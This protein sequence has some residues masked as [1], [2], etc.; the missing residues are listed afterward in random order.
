M[1]LAV[2]AR[3]VEI[4]GNEA[5]VQVGEIRRR[6]RLELIAERVRVGDYL[7]VHSG[8]AIHKLDE[9]QARLSLQEWERLLHER[10]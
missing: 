6:V 4:E 2:P 1:C 9:D 10:N 5:R 3:V 8:F 7:L